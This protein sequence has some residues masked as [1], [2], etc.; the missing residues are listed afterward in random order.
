MKEEIRV[1]KTVAPV[2]PFIWRVSWGAIFAGLFVTIVIQITLT[3]LGAAIGLASIEPLREQHP[4]Q[5]MGL[6]SGLW[7][8]VSGLVSIWIG[9][10]IAGRLCGSPARSDGLLHGIVT[11]S[12]SICVMLFLMATAAGAFLGGT[13]ALLSGAL[14]V[15]GSLTGQQNKEVA[16]SEQIKAMFSQSGAL[17]PPTGRTEGSQ[18]PGKLTQLAQQDAELAAVLARMENQGGAAKSEAERDQVVSRLTSK[19]SLEQGQATSLVDQWDQQYQQLRGQAEQKL[20][21]GGEVA[22]RGLSQAA[23]WGFIA[24]LLGLFVAAWGGWAGAPGLPVYVEQ[25]A[26]TTT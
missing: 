15:G 4:A 17:L 26:V 1:E 18:P 24:L 5:G 10:C 21:Q 7:L 20:R 25:T 22:A 23:L 11:W 19:H 12:V 8:L 13:G 16:V 3:M 14:A 2:P 9:T 6:A